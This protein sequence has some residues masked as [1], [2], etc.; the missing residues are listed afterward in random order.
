MTTTTLLA[1]ETIGVC[2]PV[3]TL[4]AIPNTRDMTTT[5]CNTAAMQLFGGQPGLENYRKLDLSF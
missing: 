3:V 2:Y 5:L 4:Y 1:K